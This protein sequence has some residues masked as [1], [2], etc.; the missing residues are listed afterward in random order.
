MA[1]SHRKGIFELDYRDILRS[2]WWFGLNK[3]S[4]CQLHKW[5]VR[6]YKKRL[7]FFALPVL[8]IDDHTGKGYVEPSVLVNPSRLTQ[9][10]ICCSSSS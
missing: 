4:E 8:V 5:D 9:A 1:H 2:H 6:L 7:Q 10:V 3:C